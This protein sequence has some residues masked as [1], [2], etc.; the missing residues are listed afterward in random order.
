M[1][2]PTI[3]NLASKYHSPLKGIIIKIADF[4]IDAGK[5]KNEPEIFYCARQKG[6]TP[7]M[8]ETRQEDTEVNLKRVPTGQNGDYLSKKIMLV[9]GYES[10]SP[11]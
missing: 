1:S 4:R 6:N 10:T 7:R 11:Y 8:M 5:V 2:T 9:T 3:Q